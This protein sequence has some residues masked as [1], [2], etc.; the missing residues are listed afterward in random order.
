MALNPPAGARTTGRLRGA[1]LLILCLAA[2]STAWLASANFAGSDGFSGRTGSTCG[3]CH[4]MPSLYAD[5]AKANLTGLPRVW[6]AGATYPLHIAVFG[7]PQAMPAPQPQGGF[8]LAV[9]QGTLAPAS[10]FE[11]L[12]RN[13]NAQDITYRPAGTLMRAWDVTW[14]APRVADLTQP[15]AET[16]VWLAVL[17]ANGNHVAATNVSDGGERFD[18]FDALTATVAPSPTVVD[19]WRRLP[20][21]APVVE[22]KL[23]GATWLVSG[24]QADGAATGVQ[25]SLDGGPLASRHTGP[26]WEL[27][28]ALAPGEHSLAVHSVGSGR[29]S[30]DVTLHVHLYAG[31]APQA[32]SQSGKAAPAF[33]MVGTVAGVVLVALFVAARRNAPSSLRARSEGIVHSRDPSSE[34]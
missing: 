19:A 24:E 18:S 32:A 31:A 21:V 2:T 25:W 14:T 28:F 15:P 1:A 8:E 5:D 9:S 12:L 3:A 22:A 13:A 29:V 4:T 6:E 23:V 34:T 30:P 7:G 27:Q 11:A 10:G 17:A 33:G 26:S 16:K 20:L